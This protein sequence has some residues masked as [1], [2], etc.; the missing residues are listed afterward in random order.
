MPQW[1]DDF[2]GLRLKL[3]TNLGLTVNIFPM[4]SPEKFLCLIFFLQSTV[5]ISQCLR[6][7]AKCFGRFAAKG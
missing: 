2:Y 3:T 5:N 1:G 4:W 6:L 7:T